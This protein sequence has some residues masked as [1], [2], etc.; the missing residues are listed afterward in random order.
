MPSATIP[1]MQTSNRF[2]EY[3]FEN[4][5][6]ERTASALLPRPCGEGGFGAAEDGWGLTSPPTPPSASPSSPVASGQSLVPSP[7]TNTLLE[8]LFNPS[9]STLDLCQLHNLSLP[10]LADLLE[11]DQF[12]RAQDATQRINAARAA[13]VEP[14]SKTLALVRTH[15]L[16]KDKPTTPAHAET[17]R[18]AAQSITQTGGAAIPPTK[19]TRALSNTQLVHSDQSHQFTSLE[20]ATM[21]QKTNRSTN[22]I[23]AT[24]VAGA[25]LAHAQSDFSYQ[26]TLNDAGAPANGTYDMR[27]TMWDD[28]TIGAPDT[29]LGFTNTRL[30]VQVEDGLFNV[31]LDMGNTSL[32]SAS[33]RYLQIQVRPAGVGS[34]ITLNPRTPIDFSPR[35]VFSLQSEQLTLP[36]IQSGPPASPTGGVFNINN[37]SASGYAIGG[38]GP[39]WGIIGY[40]GDYSP[41]PPIVT[42]AGLFGIG[43][44]VGTGGSSGT[45]SGL[46]G[47]TT[48]GSGGEFAVLGSNSGNA[49]YA[50]T[51]GS[52]HA[53]LFEKTQT[54]GST[55]ALR[56]TNA[57]TSSS[58]LGVQSIITST[59]PGANSTALR[60]ENRGTGFFGIGV[61]G[62]HAGTGWGVYGT[63]GTGGLAGN[64]GGDVF[65][66]GNLSKG[67]GTFK[68]DHPLDPENMYLSHSFVESPDMKN[69]Y[70]GVVTLDEHGNATVTMPTYFDA[71]NTEFRYQLTCIGGYAPV[72]IAE[73]ITNQQFTIA[74]GSPGLKVSW[75]ITGIRQDPFAKAHPVVVEAEK[76]G[77]DRGRYLHPEL[78]GQSKEQGIYYV[79]PDA[80]PQN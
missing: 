34:Y 25:S 30:G 70:D 61:W 7:L 11:S 49:L 63:S 42:P 60:G 75:Q 59:T 5:F 45:G 73:E 69:I 24:L 74:G 51:S 23:I 47:I 32:S 62:S 19:K 15:D 26:G 46:F 40:A 68:I 43:E 54:T 72:Y 17:Q 28:Q 79:D 16:L 2:T 78:Y 1:T 50:R 80:L 39:T 33:G 27:F 13:I 44:R 9:I 18:K 53:G 64:F 38:E 57:S 35:S 58:A 76:S 22:A 10:E 67:A 48:S 41:F 37:T 31:Q 20:R 12:R 3:D 21:S 29:Q 6:P 55:A 4:T 52:G 65:V 56:V 71:L 66:S 14:E 36:F 8:D 77:Q